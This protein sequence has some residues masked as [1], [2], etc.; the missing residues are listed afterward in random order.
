[1]AAQVK[2]QESTLSES[3]GNRTKTIAVLGSTGSIGRSAL[4]VI[5]ASQG[6]LRAII[7]VARSNTQ[8]L[9][10]QAQEQRPRLVI[11]TDPKAAAAHSWRD[12]PLETELRVGYEAVL[13]AVSADDVDMVLSAF[14]GIAGLRATWAALEA[15]KTVA[16]ANKESLVVAGSLITQLARKRKAQILPVDSEHSAIFQA[17]HG[18]Q[19]REVRR[20][21]LTASGGP[22]RSR[23]LTELA[24]VTVEEA[25]AHPTWK[26]GKKI[27]VDSAT[28]M[29]KALEIIE[30]RWL[31]G[32]EADQITVVIH[33]QSIVHSMVEFVDGS[34][35]AQLS[36]PDM[37]LPIQY[38][39]YFP[40]RRPGIARKIDWATAMD[41]RFEPP[42][43][44]RFPAIRLGLEAARIGGTAGAVLNAANEAAVECFLQ[45]R[46]RFDQIVPV[47]AKVLEAHPFDP[48]PDLDAIF[49]LDAWARKE[50]ERWI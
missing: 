48:S 44:E 24:S 45:G 9:L 25:L 15:G 6:A 23:K 36:P 26:M 8:L 13:E 28:L 22:F 42:D 37:R 33:P 39:L 30:A 31:F 47:C 14:V 1:M 17:L 12:L 18:G 3:W 41:L 38:A 49:G 34:V 2:S 5:S 29:N 16:L 50:V 11:V 20:I 46:L 27:T 7:L 43:L 19:E 10:Q 35:I 4:E 21:I 40:E 32:V